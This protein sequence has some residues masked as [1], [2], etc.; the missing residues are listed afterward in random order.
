LT[1]NSSCLS[2]SLRLGKIRFDNTIGGIDP[3][4]L[5]QQEYDKI[6]IHR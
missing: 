5:N 6:S 1:L 3:K 2:V 4:T